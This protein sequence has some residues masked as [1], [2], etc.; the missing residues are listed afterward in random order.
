MNCNIRNRVAVGDISLATNWKNALQNVD[1]VVHLAARVHVME[2]SSIDP[3][4]KY[5]K[6]NVDATL[7]LARQ[8]AQ[9]GVHRFIF[10][11]TIKVNG[12]Q[13][14]PGKPFTEKDVPAPID[15]YSISKYE[16]EQELRK[17]ADRTGMEVVVIRPVL[18]YGPGV[19]GNFASMMHYLCKGLPLPFGAIHNQR[20]LIALDNLVDLIITCIGHPAAANQIFFASDGEDMSTTDLFKRMAGALNLPLRLIPIPEKFL[21]LG[22]TLLGKRALALRLLGSLQVDITKAQALLGWSPQVKVEKAFCDTAHFYL[23]SVRS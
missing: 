13:S 7:N 16:A 3:L 15:A 18:V 2:D 5:R 1:C 14:S 20:S 17:L 11:S 23:E 10:I 4:I 6:I 21:M 12:E 22:A 19:K 9:A 8:A